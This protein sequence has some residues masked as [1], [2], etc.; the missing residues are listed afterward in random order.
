MTDAGVPGFKAPPLFSADKAYERW[1]NELKFWKRMTKVEKKQQ[2][3]A[4]TLSLPKG[5]TVREKIF[6]ELDLHNLDWLHH[7]CMWFRLV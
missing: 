4:V 6:S 2:G 7:Y 5:S 3:T 1:V